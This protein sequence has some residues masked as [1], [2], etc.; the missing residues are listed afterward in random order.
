VWAFGVGFAH[1]RK[2]ATTWAECGPQAHGL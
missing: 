1:G 2:A